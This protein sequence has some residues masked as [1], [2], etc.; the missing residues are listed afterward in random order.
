MPQYKQL[1]NSGVRIKF[2]WGEYK[3]SRITPTKRRPTST[4]HDI[5]QAISIS[6]LF[7]HLLWFQNNFEAN[8]ELEFLKGSDT[9]ENY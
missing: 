9:P 1:T 7:F 3:S 8:P 2:Q 5:L 4:F 6:F